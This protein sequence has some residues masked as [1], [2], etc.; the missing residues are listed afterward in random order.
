[1]SLG[2]IESETSKNKINV[3]KNNSNMGKYDW[4]EIYRER[5]INGKN[6]N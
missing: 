2:N 5:Y 6:D 1:M 4:N 3:S